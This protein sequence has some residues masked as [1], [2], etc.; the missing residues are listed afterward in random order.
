[1]LDFFY[2]YP[3]NAPLIQGV[4]LKQDLTLLKLLKMNFNVL[5][6][7]HMHEFFQFSRLDHI[8]KFTQ[9]FTIIISYYQ[10]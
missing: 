7:Q 2:E 5:Y 8:C 1:M 3:V 9:K 6:Y 4:F 10:L